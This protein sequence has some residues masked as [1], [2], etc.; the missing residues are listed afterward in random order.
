[1]DKTATQRAAHTFLREHFLSGETFTLDDFRKVTG[2]QKSGTLN[3]YLRK[4]YRGL[5]EN[6]D[7]GPL[8]SE[9]AHYRVTEAF[10]RFVEWKH[11]RQHVTQVRIV[12]TSHERVR[13]KVLI[14]EFLM[15]L[16]HE[17]EL[18]ITLDTL[19]FKDTI[20]RKLKAI[21][22]KDLE[23]HF[24]RDASHTNEEHLNKIVDFIGGHFV[25]YSISHVDGR[26]RAESIRDYDAVAKL[27][28]G[29]RR[30]LIDETTAVTRFI[31]PYEDNQELE[32]V[33]FL[34]H[35]L[36]VRSMIGLAEGESEV[37]MLESGPEQ[38]V[39]IWRADDG[40]EAEEED[41]SVES[42]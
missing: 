36:F 32:S 21:R 33:R 20:L 40:E 3:T 10:R 28:K 11:F 27:L 39:H 30:Y 42:E 23:A 4:Q 7:G 2:W 15:P 35:E 24:P 25:G 12:L 14:Y 18:R 41:E 37:W 17:T 26:F 34:F 6:I 19:F 1:M 5:I 16:T 9:T 13:S 38:R 29:A 22:S 8:I 31:F